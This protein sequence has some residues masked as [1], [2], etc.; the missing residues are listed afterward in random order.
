MKKVTARD[1]A[2]QVLKV[3]E[4]EGAYANLALNRY[5]ELYQPGKL[6]RAFATEITYGV[7]RNLNTID[8]VL[9]HFLKQPLAA[10]TVWVRNI[11]RMGTYQIMFMPRVPDSA[12]C[13]ESVEL[14]KKYGHTG[15]AKFVNGVLR[16]V[17]RQQG[18]LDFPDPQESPIDYISLKYSHPTWLVERWLKEFG[19]DQTVAL[20]KA[21]NHPAPNTIRTNTLKINRT[22][23]KARLEF[24]GVETRVT[25]YAPEGLHLNGFLSYQSLP[26]FQEGLFQVQDESSMLVAHALN[27][28]SGARI[29]DVASAPGGK[30]T[31]LAQLMKDRGEIVAVDIHPHKLELIKENCQRLGIN[32]I[33]T[34]LAD[35]RC[36]PAEYTN[37]ADYVLVDAPCSGLGVLRRRPDARWRKDPSQL[38]GIVRLQREIL[39][40]ASTYLRPGGVLIYST[41]TITREE[42][43]GVL[44]AFLADHPEFSLGDLRQFL[45]PGLAEEETAEN[46]FIQLLPHIHGMDG[47][48]IARLRKK[49]FE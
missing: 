29:I 36:L 15:A 26:S 7:L 12:A 9:A 16:N 24:E 25:K 48:F 42:N 18:E 14:A 23:L 13:N 30:T 34:L 31:H 2:L 4:E 5:L 20:C 33:R 3:V 21:N 6:D 17:A 37:W 49:G 28:A 44:E 11:L 35:A 46:G 27:P 32:S 22:D 43:I 10:Q 39:E 45:P 40:S 41:C 19:F 38:P 1:L 47:F 8:W